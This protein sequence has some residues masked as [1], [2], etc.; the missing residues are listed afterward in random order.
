MRQIVVYFQYDIGIDLYALPS[1]GSSISAFKVRP[2]RT[3]SAAADRDRSPLRQTAFCVAGPLMYTLGPTEDT[4][5]DN[6]FYCFVQVDPILFCGVLYLIS[7]TL[8]VMHPARLKVSIS[9]FTI[10]SAFNLS[11]C[12]SF[13]QHGTIRFPLEEFS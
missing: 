4:V 5:Q 11:V 8:A 13:R 2:H 3:R 7:S 6:C 9:T 12:P 10:L 1:N